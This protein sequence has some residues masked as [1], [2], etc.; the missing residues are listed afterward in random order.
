MSGEAR[1]RLFP[2]LASRPLD[3]APY[4]GSVL[5]LAISKELVEADGRGLY[6]GVEIEP[7]KVS[8]FWFTVPLSRRRCGAIR[9]QAGARCSRSW[10]CRRRA[11]RIRLAR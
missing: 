10:R 1:D 3:L 8:P 11:C 9:P 4:C 5:G 2:V 7:C 6:I